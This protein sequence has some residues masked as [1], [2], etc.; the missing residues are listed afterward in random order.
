MKIK[1]AFVLVTVLQLYGCA[2]ELSKKDAE[3]NAWKRSLPVANADYGGYPA[4]YETLIKIHL[5]QTLKDPDSVRYGAFSLPRQEH[6]IENFMA[7]QAIYGYSVC[8][9]VNAKNSYGGYTGSHVFWYFI[10]NGEILRSRDT[11]IT[12]TTIYIGRSINCEDGSLR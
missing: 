2:S 4:N 3:A 5:S 7:Q 8:V 6:V 1:M 11:T 10:R 9:S 12:G